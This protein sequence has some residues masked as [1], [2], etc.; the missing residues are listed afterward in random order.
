MGAISNGQEESLT[1]DQAFAVAKRR[2]EEH[3]EGTYSET[4]NEFLCRSLR[5]HIPQPHRLERVADLVMEQYKKFVGRLPDIAVWLKIHNDNPARY[6]GT[7]QGE[8]FQCDKC[9]DKGRIHYLIVSEKSGTWDGKSALCDCA[10]GKRILMGDWR[11]APQTFVELPFIKR[12]LQPNRIYYVN[13]VACDN[14]TLSTLVLKW[15][16]GKLEPLTLDELNNDLKV[17]IEVLEK[18]GFPESFTR[19][20]KEFL[21]KEQPLPAE[22]AIEHLQEQDDIPF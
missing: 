20:V 4:D 18:A 21:N 1:W 6:P 9:E 15:I 7:F 11:K 17:D 22:V 14:E 13:R 2:I 19:R 12:L 5:R 8:R 10:N 3:Y 16:D